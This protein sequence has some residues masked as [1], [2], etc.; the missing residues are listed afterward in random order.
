MWRRLKAP[1]AGPDG[2]CIGRH[3][4]EVAAARAHLLTAGR[5]GCPIGR[6]AGVCL[7]RLEQASSG[8]THR[9][10]RPAQAITGPAPVCLSTSSAPGAE[11]R[12]TVEVGQDDA[13]ST[14]EQSRSDA[15]VPPVE[16][17]D[18]TRT[19]MTPESLTLSQP[20]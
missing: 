4:N 8:N 5:T 13:G 19:W 9:R 6:D 1:V 3:I 20:A 15:T 14:R 17:S 18:A 12:M 7:R 2:A 11:V 10:A 16:P